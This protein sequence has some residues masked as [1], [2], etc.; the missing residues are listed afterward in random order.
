MG[1]KAA[2]TMMPYG[3]RFQKHRRLLQE[4]LNEKQC[5]SYQPLQTKSTRHLLARLIDNPDNWM[6][7]LERFSAEII[8]KIAYG[9]DIVDNDPYLD[10]AENALISLTS[11]GSVGGTPVD[12]LPFLRYLPSWFPGTYYAFK[13]R[14]FRPAIIKMHDY[15]FALV[16][17][18]MKEGN[19]QK[20]YLT[21]HL[22]ELH[23]K[24]PDEE[25]L[26]DLK[27]SAGIM[28]VGG[29]E[30]T[31]SVILFFI[32]AMVLY[33]EFQKKAQKE[34]D[35]VVGKDRFP[36]LSDRASLPYV[37]AVMYEVVRWHA[38]V[39]SGLPHRLLEDDIYNGMFIPKGTVI[40]ENIFAILRDEKVYADPD[41]FNPSRYLPKPEGNAESYLQASSGSGVGK[42]CPGRHLADRT[43]FLVLSSILATLNIGRAK[44]QNGKEIVPKEELIT[45][46]SSHPK[47]FICTIKPRDRTAETMI[48]QAQLWD[49]N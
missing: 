46:V 4:Y 13:A 42:V 18:Q 9:I 47:P 16:E 24:N 45:G 32:L 15:P 2:I 3:K 28:F 17:K 21:H 7:H 31:A 8:V 23:G 26:E 40:V 25:H 10:I 34:I 43:L 11:C 41:S 22:D 38:P 37:N 12:F 5:V 39:P 36:E 1:W 48:R 6:K 27:G 14:S 35:H 33:P 49:E 30:T 44:D 29:A 19:P 20:S